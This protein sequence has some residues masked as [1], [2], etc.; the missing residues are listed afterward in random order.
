M[1]PDSSLAGRVTGLVTEVDDLAKSVAS[2]ARSL[3]ASENRASALQKQLQLERKRRSDERA[4][5]ASNLES[6]R[7]RVI[8]GESRTRDLSAAF[9]NML[10][11]PHIVKAIQGSFRETPA[12]VG[13]ASLLGKE[14][15][16]AQDAEDESAIQ[17]LCRA[18]AT[19]ASEPR[20]CAL[21]AKGG[22]L[23]PALVGCAAAV[24]ASLAAKAPGVLDG[25]AV[26]FGA[27]SRTQVTLTQMLD[28]EVDTLLVRW[29]CKVPHAARF[30]SLVSTM[31]RL[32]EASEYKALIAVGEQAA[33][34]MFSE[35]DE[36]GH[37]PITQAS[38]AM[39][40]KLQ[41]CL[42]ETMLYG[43]GAGMSAPARRG[44]FDLS[45]FAAP[46]PGSAAAASVG[47]D[48]TITSYFGASQ[49]AAAGAGQGDSSDVF[50]NI[51]GDPPHWMHE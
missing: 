18:T 7:A 27:L 33:T 14:L 13:F 16:A 38:S 28:V 32:M 11:N 21:A 25:F 30:P 50:G 8:S 17:T 6:V 43:H 23:V 34:R 2:A 1:S 26:T 9:L 5:A 45:E 15:R 51:G 3:K 36:T 10:A 40:V 44:Q 12:Y 20:F 49:A 42:R 29:M 48:T 19:L 46:T 47:R 4:E 41:M 24:G 37:D 31:Q 39:R 22:E 35:M